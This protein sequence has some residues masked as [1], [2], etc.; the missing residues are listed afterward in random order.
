MLRNPVQ[1]RLEKCVSWQ[2][3]TFM[4]ALCERM[5]PNY[6]LFCKETQFADAYQYRVVLDAVWEILTVKSAKINFDRQLEKVEEMVPSESD[7]DLYLVYPAID[8]CHALADLLHALLDKDE[9]PDFCQKISNISVKTVA[10]L[11]FAQTG[12]EVTD[13]NQ[14]ENEAVCLEWDTQWDIYRA[15]RDEESR[16]VEM[17]KDLRFEL[18]EDCVSNIGIEL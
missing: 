10:D 4:A 14:K 8:A 12:I 1:L 7:F 9:I 17:I 18:R 5:Y 16:N 6:A 11:E 3:L 2:H 13:E 15:F